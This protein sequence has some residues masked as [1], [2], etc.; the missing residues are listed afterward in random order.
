MVWKERLETASFR[1]V[2]FHIES[3]NAS[4]GRRVQTH[5]FPNR[6]KPYSEDLGR[7]ALRPNITAYV[8]GDD[9][10]AQRDRLLEAL[11]K[12]GPGTLIHPTL[13]KMI[14]CVTDQIKVSTASNEGRM[15]RFDLHFVEAGELAYPQADAATANILTSSCSAVD[16]AVNQLFAGFS[17]AGMPDFLQ[18]QVLD[19]VGQMLDTITAAVTLAD[20]AAFDVIRLLKGD[21]SVLLPPPSSGTGFVERVKK[22]WNAG[23]RLADNSRRLHTRIKNLSGIALNNGLAPRGLW[24]TDSATTRAA[25]QQR[26]LVASVLR[27]TALSEAALAVTALAAP[28]GLAQESTTPT[29]GWPTLSHPAL[30][31]AVV[32]QNSQAELLTWDALVD[33]RDT[34]NVALDREIKRASDDG[35][36]LALRRLKSSL[37]IDISARLAQTEKT[38]V[39]TPEEVTPALVLAAAWYDAAGRETDIIQRNGVA[40]PGF[41]P[42]SA[43][44]VP[45]R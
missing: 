27:T 23:N 3:E 36:F 25:T 15:V 11:N 6:D 30:N 41:V 45:V 42:V 44:R 32:P 22:L 38:V 31:N 29:S 9:C 16:E 1:G 5:E 33:L 26:N 37:N 7:I 39:R 24:K 19:D 17:L 10:L 20:R 40:H 43:L 28:A 8:M 2:S 21:I 34:L 14:V 13:G 18:G 12:P 35:V 4:F